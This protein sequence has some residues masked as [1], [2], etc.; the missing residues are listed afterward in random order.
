M[1]K[2]DCLFFHCSHAKTAEQIYV[3]FGVEITYF[4]RGHVKKLK[5]QRVFQSTI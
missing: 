5:A 1:D 2:F 4:S 3:Q